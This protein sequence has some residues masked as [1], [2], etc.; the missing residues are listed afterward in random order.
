MSSDRGPEPN[1]TPNST[2]HVPEHV[3]YRPFA[4]ETVLLNLE[5]GHYH[6]VN[7]TGGRMLEALEKAGTVR[8]AAAQLAEEYDQPRDGVEQDLCAFC[9]DLVERG[10]VEVDGSQPD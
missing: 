1:V 4:A 9:A 10:L 3:V 7:P 2:V 8:E 5:T 6:G